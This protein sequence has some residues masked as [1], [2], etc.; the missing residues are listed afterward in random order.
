MHAVAVGL[1]SRDIIRLWLSRWAERGGSNTC[2]GGSKGE[3]RHML[4]LCGPTLLLHRTIWQKNTSDPKMISQTAKRTS[5]QPT[6]GIRSH[7]P[8]LS[9]WDCLELFSRVSLTGVE[10]TGKQKGQTWHCVSQEGGQIYPSRLQVLTSVISAY[11]LK[12]GFLDGKLRL[13]VPALVL[14]RCF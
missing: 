5:S 2:Q 3:G 4:S 14:P 9:V 11:S 13:L 10:K 6:A 1:R 7:A 8:F 12:P